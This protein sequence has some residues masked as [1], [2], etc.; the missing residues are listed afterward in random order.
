MFEI[1]IDCIII[2]KA[3]CAIL[4]TDKVKKEK[5]IYL[6]VYSFALELWAKYLRLIIHWFFFF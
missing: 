1:I 2:I 4:C 3:M 6:A 5:S